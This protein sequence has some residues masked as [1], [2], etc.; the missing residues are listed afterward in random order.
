MNDLR[1]FAGALT[2][3]LAVAIGATAAIIDQAPAAALTNCTVADLSMDGEETAFLGLINQYRVQNGFGALGVSTNLNRAASW[4]AVDLATKNYFSHTDSLGRA[5]AQLAVDCGYP[6]GAGENLAAGTV[7]DTAQEAFDAWKASA[8]HNANMLTSYY[9]QIG[10]ARYYGSSSTYGWYWVTEFGA[11][12]DGTSGT[13][14]GTSTPPPVTI[15]KA[16]ITSPIN[17]ATLPGASATFSWSAGSGGVEY[18]LYAGSSVGANNY[19]GAS[20]GTA[21]SRTLA[22]L[23]TNGSTVYVRLWTRF[24]TGWQYNDYSYRAATTTTP[25]AT[26][27]KASLLSPV[28]GSFLAR[29]N[30]TFTWTQA[31]GGLEYFLYVGTAQGANNLYGRSQGTNTAVTISQLVATSGTTWVRLWTRTSAGWAFS[32]YSFAGVR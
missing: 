31:T 24:S 7:R 23:P 29:V 18:F 14:G 27:S 19:Y 17:G 13:G 6:T 20:Q 15:A 11:T 21:L 12:N 2:A 1:R 4:K 16:A 25:P 9:Q 28:P 32:D 22:G 10:I 5:P 8:G 26:S 3:A 30:S